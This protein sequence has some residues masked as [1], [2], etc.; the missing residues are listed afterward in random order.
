MNKSTVAANNSIV[1]NNGSIDVL[2]SATAYFYVLLHEGVPYVR[3][4]LSIVEKFI[5]LDVVYQCTA[6]GVVCV[7]LCRLQV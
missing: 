7:P 5:Y 4:L 6:S 3:S 2:Y 1:N